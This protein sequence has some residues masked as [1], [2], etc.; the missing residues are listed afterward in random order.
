MN[1]FETKTNT[2]LCACE[3]ITMAPRECVVNRCIYVEQPIICPC[4]TRY[5]NH[6]IPRPVYYYSYSQQEENVCHMNK[7]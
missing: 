7:K 1:P 6:Y 2:P 4:V 5:V 3:P